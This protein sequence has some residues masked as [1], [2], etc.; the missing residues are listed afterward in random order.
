LYCKFKF[1]VQDSETLRTTLPWP[2]AVVK[3]YKINAFW[4][5]PDPPGL[6]GVVNKTQPKAPLPQ[7]G[8]GMKLVLS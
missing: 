4:Y 7:E 2:I 6:G 3:W 8:F 1:G 5:K